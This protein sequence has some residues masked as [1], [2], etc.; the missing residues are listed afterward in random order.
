MLLDVSML[1]HSGHLAIVLK[2]RK[3]WGGGG[4]LL[5]LKVMIY[6]YKECKIC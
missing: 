2:A 1:R 6:E 5:C 4:E 3:I